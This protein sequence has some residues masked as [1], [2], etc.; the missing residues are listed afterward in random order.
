MSYAEPAMS[1]DTDAATPVNGSAK[2][3]LQAFI[4]RI[5]RLEE[6]K[7]AI[8]TDIREVY[9]EAKA[10]GFDTKAMRAIIAIRKKPESERLEQEAILTTYMQA[11]GMLP[12]LPEDQR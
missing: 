6:E 5:E 3:Q 7:A 1:S 2:T 10:E 4:E 12:D 9:L 11:L 8:A